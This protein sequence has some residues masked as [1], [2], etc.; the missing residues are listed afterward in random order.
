VGVRVATSQVDSSLNDI[1]DCVDQRNLPGLPSIGV[2]VHH[3]PPP[4]AVVH[5]PLGSQQAQRRG[6]HFAVPSDAN[7][8]AAASGTHCLWSSRRGFHRRLSEYHPKR[9]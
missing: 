1:A 8:N 3:G 7:V 9:P 5:S 4:D 6:H 2:L